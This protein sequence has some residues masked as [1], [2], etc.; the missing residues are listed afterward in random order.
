PAL[1]RGLWPAVASYRRGR[2]RLGPGGHRWRHGRPQGARPGAGHGSHLVPCCCTV[3]AA[4]PNPLAST[5]AARPQHVVLLAGN[6]TLTATALL[7]A[8]CRRAA[9]WA[10]QG[11][12]PG[13]TVALVGP[14]D[15]DFVVGL[16]ALG[17]LGAAVAPLLATAPNPAL[18][19]QLRL[20]QAT[21][22]VIGS[23]LDGAEVTRLTAI[24]AAADVP[25]IK[26]MP[27]QGTAGD[28]ATAVAERFWPLDEVR[29]VL[30]SS[31]T[32]GAPHVV[33]VTTGQLLFS[34]FGSATRL[35]HLPG[36]RWLC[37][38]PLHH[39]GGL[40][41]LFRALWFGASVQ[42][43]APFDAAAVAAALDQ[44]GITLTSLVPQML[45]QVLASRA[46]K[47]FPQALRAILLGGAPTPGALLERCRQRQVPVCVTWGMSETASQVATT[48]P[49]DWDGPG[50]CGPPLPFVRVQVPGPDASGSLQVWGPVV[51]QASMVTRDIG[52]VDA[53]GRVRVHGRDDDLIISGG[54]NIAPFE[55]ESVLL[56]YPG[57]KDAAVVGRADAR[58]GER[59]VAVLVAAAGMR[60][61][62]AA[63]VAWCR[64][65][66]ATFK[67]P[68]Q[69]IWCD[70]LPRDAL[71]KLRRKQVLPLLHQGVGDV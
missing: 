41:I 31:G 21:A 3:T 43:A 44:G 53:T 14:A 15:L 66:L 12:K 27:A 42:L 16:H 61:D 37:C 6:A 9:M 46:A 68:A 5:A 47:P 63:L 69:F 33:P 17:W 2:G 59:P 4:V 51:H 35:G 64:G 18:Q 1:S 10:A 62:D 34:A 40:S 23:G 8:V 29:L 48:W 52:S 24:A 45:A 38:L 13:D 56:A 50:D 57:I 30:L 32:T 28:N 11:V 58:W 60:P 39:I 36:D 67:V 49:G 54:E 26:A 55:V 22:L 71:G 7:Q 20:V 70:A 19:Q 65:S 25:C